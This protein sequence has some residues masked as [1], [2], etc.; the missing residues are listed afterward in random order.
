[1]FTHAWLL[2]FLPL[3]LVPILL[4]LLSRWRVRMV[5]LSTVRFLV[6]SD[7][8]QRRQSRWIE[9]LIL[10]LR[11]LFLAFVVLTI[12][13]PVA[14]SFQR[15]FTGNS[16]R[17]VVLI[18]D[19]SAAM[20]LRSGGQTSLERSE[21]AALT[22][23]NSLKGDDHLT[24]IEA[25]AEPR[26]LRAGFVH[27]RETFL[28]IVE[29]LQLGAAG[30]DIGGAV[31]MACGLSAHG[32]RVVVM[33][34]DARQVT[35]A[36]LANQ[37]A[38]S[39]V[40]ANTSLVVLN[41][42][43]TEPVV[44]VGVVGELPAEMN[45]TVG[46]P[47]LLKAVITCSATSSFDVKNVKP[48]SR[49]LRVMLED[50]VV[51]QM[52][53][54]LLPGQRIERVI[55]VTPQSAGWVRGKFELSGD[56]FAEDDSFL[57]GLN[58]AENLNVLVVTGP[59]SEEAAERP[60]LFLETALT[61][62]TGVILSGAVSVTSIA[63]DE[64]TDVQLANAEVVILADA[65]ID[66]TR[67]VMLRRYLDN[68][69]G[70]LV[71]PGPVMQMEVINTHLLAGPAQSGGT[72]LRYANATGDPNDEATFQSIG[73]VSVDHPILSVFADAKE[74]G[75]RGGFFDGVRLYRFH[76]L[77]I[78]TNEPPHRTLIAL[79]DG[80]PVLVETAV[81]RGR[82]ML[83][84][85]AAT[86][87]WSNLPVSG[88]VFVPLMV[89]T[90]EHLRRASPVNITSRIEPGQRARIT[91]SDGWPDAKAQLTD[92]TGRQHLIE[93]HRDDRSRIGIFE[94]TQRKGFYSFTIL[95]GQAQTMAPMTQGFA[96]NLDA[97]QSNVSAMSEPQVRKLFGSRDVTYLQ[98]SA[99]DPQL[100]RE[101][102]RKSELWRT[103]IWLLLAIIGF[104]FMLST[105][106]NV[107]SE[108][109]F[110]R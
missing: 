50:R 74:L 79:T 89:R 91:I 67:A 17:D 24:L 7:P 61:K 82:L 105:R 22:I 64:L 81:G 43:A 56:G 85:F 23:I 108:K 34:S 93:L 60:L 38:L 11:I 75:R 53:V 96:V 26:M 32:P 3:A 45:A 70:L 54:E 97:R 44:N 36:S 48:V 1:M 52:T 15:L 5:E 94:A 14:T 80:R 9:R 92:A 78:G 63:H 20:A 83:A 6:D 25:G 19:T 68:G 29:A 18:F 10:L 69:G 106:S 90:V 30:S 58:I 33:L 55:S 46:L 87:G 62:A 8:Q 88:N 107:K 98:G 51:E 86:P 59:A 27:E 110:K 4:H 65:P 102:M 12:S 77:E 100:A 76:P 72:S 41:L 73:K 95:P 71:M 103:L 101:L 84:S 109:A 13:R 16:A 21:A 31:A 47:V 39:E 37:P 66:P 40:D 49:V 2:W 99:D 42:G 28:G 104:E 57:F 35:W